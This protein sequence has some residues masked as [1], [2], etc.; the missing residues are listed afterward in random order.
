MF[1]TPVYKLLAA[2]DTGGARGHQAGIVIPADIEDFFPDVVGTISV[3]TPTVDVPVEAELVVDNRSVAR[4]ETRYQYQTWGG[5]RSPERRLTG[6]LGALRNVANADDM[7]LFSRDPEKPE[8]IVIRLLRKGGE[9]YNEIVSA[10][11]DRRWGI[12]PG[13]PRP[14]GNKDIT[15][16]EDEISNITSAEFFMFDSSRPVLE[17]QFQKK[18]RSA[19]FR[20][21]LLRTYGSCCMASGEQINTPSGQLN[22]DA[23][24]IVPVE[25]GGTDDIRNGI[26]LSKDLHWAFDN[27][28]FSLNR[29]FRVVLSRH[30]ENSDKCEPLKRIASTQ[31]LFGAAELRPHET[32]VN[33]HFENRFLK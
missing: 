30:A 32:A 14:V 4:V 11:P 17:T 7:V 2:N 26:L 13:L 10:N 22:L 5:T 20:K 24:H 31:L 1:D 6:S 28:L 27:G 21:S 23:A 33:W 25:L 19:A 9:E 15:D 18:A 8:L 16:A 3:D 12:V 29:D